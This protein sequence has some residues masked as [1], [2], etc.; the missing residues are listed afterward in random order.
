[1]KI[2]SERRKGMKKKN[3]GHQP[4]IS[5]RPKRCANIPGSR[6]CQKMRKRG[7]SLCREC[8]AAGKN[9]VSV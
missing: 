6:A 9:S 1:M 2:E 3:G 8:T 7:N 4:K 5:G